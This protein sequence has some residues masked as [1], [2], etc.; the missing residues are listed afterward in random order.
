MAHSLSPS[1]SPTPTRTSS[2]ANTSFASVVTLAAW[3]VRRTWF[4]LLMVAL[5]MIAAIVV[6]SAV[7]LFLPITTT[8]GL[9][10]MLREQNANIRIN[11]DV[12]PLGLSSNVVQRIQQQVNPIFQQNVGNYLGGRPQLII[13]SNNID[14]ISPLVLGE[15]FFHVYSTSMQ[16]AAS[17]ITLVQGRL[18][19]VT[20][21]P[22]HG[23][24]IM[25]T[26]DNAQALKL[27]VGSIM[28]LEM[29][30][31]T[32]IPDPFSFM[33]NTPP[34]GPIGAP[35]KA[36]VVGLFTV[37]NS[38]LAYWQGQNFERYEVKRAL[39]SHA[40]ED[41]VHFSLLFP[42][43]SLLGLYDG[44]ATKYHIQTPFAIS[45]N[46]LSWSY[47]FNPA[48]LTAAQLDTIVGRMA[49][50]K[51]IFD[52]RFA[53]AQ[54]FFGYP[55]DPSNPPPFPYIVQVTLI[56]PLLSGPGTP[57]I[58]EQYR[59]RVAVTGIPVFLIALQ[60]L[61]LTLFFVSLMTDLL[62]ERQTDTIAILRSRGASRG[63]VFGALM[64][65]SVALSIVTVALGIP[66]AI[67]VVLFVSQRI[68]PTSTQDAL[69]VISAYPLASALSAIGYAIAVV[70]AMLVTMS[71]SLGRAARMDVLSVR[72]SASRLTRT[73]LWQR[74]RLDIVFG[75]IALAGFIISLYLSSVGTPLSSTAQALV[76]VPLSLIA[77]FFF[78]LGCLLLSLRLLPFLLQL[79][80]RL[81][82]RGRS[83]TSMLALAQMARIPQQAVRMTLLL[84][85]VIAFTIFGL[86]FSSSQ[87]QR[88]NDTAAYQVGADFRGT[89]PTNS[90]QLS[91]QEWT[92]TYETLPGVISASVGYANN[93]V[94][95]GGQQALHLYVQAVDTS[96]Y[97]DTARWPQGASSQSLSSLM[98]LLT[99]KRAYG[100]SHAVVPV[101]VDETVSSGL[102]VHVGST[103]HA[104]VEDDALLINDLSCYVVGIVQH[105]PTPADAINRSLPAD[106]TVTGG[107][108]MDY[109]T[110][111]AIYTQAAQNLVGKGHTSILPNTIWL[112]TRD[113]ASLLVQVRAALGRGNFYLNN[114]QDRRAILDQ[115]HSDP[116]TIT[117]TAM[118]G[119]GMVAT[120]LL[121]ILGDVLASW[122]N[123]RT[124]ITNFVVLRAL[125][126]SPRQVASVLIWEQA[127]VY[128]VGLLLGVAFGLLLSI[129]IVPTLIFRNTGAQNALPPHII[130][131]STLL[132]ALLCVVAVFIIALGMMVYIVSKPS[133]SETLRVN[134]D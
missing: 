58:L 87:E 74:L 46:T 39:S 36:R 49:H 25:M 65:Q 64:A 12:D 28:Q 13:D 120:L 129:T 112:R 18:P 8:A 124:R 97:A 133:M 95:A 66:L 57:S 48:R 78:V 88:V 98:T 115:L 110:Y 6:A 122:L 79:G 53:G 23:I 24:E 42:L 26:P 105:L 103:F 72:R 30:F 47:S 41:I 125:G 123:A 86:V 40:F 116:L 75:V 104:T 91:V 32:Q 102:A 67:L 21:N 108:L 99:S 50:L 33:P 27:H 126:T 76:V 107:V 121:A 4:L 38:N 73:P 55:Y 10:G 62:V 132:I 60:I 106:T 3:R 82:V 59:S 77:P 89:I 90:P 52:V 9:R 56:S 43:E 5:G 94:V 11:C 111:N 109:Q 61:G 70:L 71:F 35:I 45:S 19:R 44:L 96:T 51:S 15:H 118:L 68:L 14:S 54:G 113:D 134:E 114:V 101:V 127:L 2:R 81:A 17:H 63:Q 117:L 93:A 7:P 1:P 80:A 92:T 83:A 22:A 16:E 31:Y 130:I 34:S 29:S 20:S 119:L 69:G 37:N 84:A 100:V 128:S 85:L 131:P